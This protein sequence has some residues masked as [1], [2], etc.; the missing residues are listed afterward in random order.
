MKTP[1]TLLVMVIAL[2]LVSSAGNAEDLP[3]AAMPRDAKEPRPAPRAKAE[4]DAVLAGAP[5]PPEKTRPIKLVLAAGKKDHGKGEHDYPAWQ[6][7]W[8]ELFKHA[9]DVETST[10]WE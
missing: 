1:A 5:N 3:P 7:A 8:G 6:K 10:A 2:G 4:V 9:K